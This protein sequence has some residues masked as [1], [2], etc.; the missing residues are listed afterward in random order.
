MTDA[1]TYLPGIL[2]IYGVF[3]LQNAT[4]G[5]NVLAV[6]G[7]SMAL[8]KR[9][10]LA[11]SV[12]VACGTLTW[13]TASVLGLAAFIASYGQLLFLIKILGGLYLCY[14]AYKAFRA[15]F[16]QVDIEFAQST[17]RNRTAWSFFLKGYVLNMTNPKAA[18]GWIAIVSLGMDANSP[19]WVMAAIIIGTTVLSLLVH[20]SYTLVF[21][22]PKMDAAY[23][24]ARRPIQAALGGLFA[25]A[26]YRLLTTKL[27]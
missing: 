15:A 23:V 22:A 18:F 17:E 13:S 5:P 9:A 6:A 12:G 11:V 21:S 7:T 3:L 8:G 27:P 24:R 20:V 26:G 14:L 4:P 16:S 1:L 2:L 25:F 19:G 10:G